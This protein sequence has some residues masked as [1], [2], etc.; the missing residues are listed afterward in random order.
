MSYLSII[1]PHRRASELIDEQLDAERGEPALAR[2]DSE[3]LESHLARCEKCAE[4]LAE[5]RMLMKKV[6]SIGTAKAP[7]GF[8][9][10]VM[11]RAKTRRVEEP[12]ARE[13]FFRPLMPLSQLALGVAMVAVLAV[14]LGVMMAVGPGESTKK[15]N[16]METT[17]V[18][19]A[20]A[21]SDAPHFIVRAPGLGAA[22]A[23]RDITQV[24]EAHRGT[25]SEAGS[26]IIARIP[27]GDLVGVTQD[28]ANRAS[29]RMT[30][31]DAGELPADLATIVIRFELD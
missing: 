19:Q 6:R 27:R 16:G 4:Q 5:R 11:L 23:R 15:T 28:L 10:R 31:A 29:F 21:I 14:S 8:A 17:S 12:E 24:V 30:K 18:G 7:A 25:F 22:K 13:G 20:M 1:L 3:W 9:G 26:T 2:E